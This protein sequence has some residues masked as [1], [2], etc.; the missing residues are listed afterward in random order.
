M[1]DLSDEVLLRLAVALR[2][3]D[4]PTPKCKIQI[5]DGYITWDQDHLVLER[6]DQMKIVGLNEL[7][8]EN[9]QFLEACLRIWMQNVDGFF[10]PVDTASKRQTP[11]A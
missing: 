6:W 8:P 9:K 4:G 2:K 5:E 11:E 1:I 7:A 10:C 3:S